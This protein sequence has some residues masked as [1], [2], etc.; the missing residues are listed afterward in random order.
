MSTK[1]NSRMHRIGYKGCSLCTLGSIFGRWR[2]GFGQRVGL[3]E[4]FEEEAGG[5][6]EAIGVGVEMVSVGN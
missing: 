5:V 2:V 3:L 6:E 1:G 4:E